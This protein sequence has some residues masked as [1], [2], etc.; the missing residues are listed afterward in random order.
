[1][2]KVFIGNVTSSPSY[3]NTTIPAPTIIASPTAATTPSSDFPTSNLPYPGS[4]AP[5]ELLAAA[6]PPPVDEADACPS[7]DEQVLFAAGGLTTCAFPPQ[8]QLELPFPFC[9]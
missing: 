5:V 1:M 9:E 7:R 4:A 6:A 3:Y 2:K 8:S